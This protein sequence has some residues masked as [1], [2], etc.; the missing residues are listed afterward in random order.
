M[1]GGYQ[2]PDYV[3]FD[4]LIENMVASKVSTVDFRN[5]FLLSMHYFTSSATV[6][7]HLLKAL[8]A[9]PVLSAG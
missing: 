8:V 7:D 5:V 9:V 3:S 6:L 4:S 2:D 1:L